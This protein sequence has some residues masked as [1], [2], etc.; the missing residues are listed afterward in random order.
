MFA[1]KAS[2]NFRRAVARTAM[3]RGIA[4]EARSH[5]E[6]GPAEI[7]NGFRVAVRVACMDCRLGTPKVEAIFVEE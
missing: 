7:T 3:V 1:V 2:Q 5:D 4:R 6:W